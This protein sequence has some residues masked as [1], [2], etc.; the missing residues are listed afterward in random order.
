MAQVYKSIMSG[1]AAVKNEK[2][3]S[4]FVG[5]LLLPLRLNISILQSTP[6]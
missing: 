2:L 1:R 3:L 6:Y 4:L 5:S